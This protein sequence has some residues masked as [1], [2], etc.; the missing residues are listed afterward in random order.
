MLSPQVA[1]EGRLSAG[2]S[3]KLQ[4]LL[5]PRPR[6]D[7]VTS[8]VHSYWSKLV[9]SPARWKGREVEPTSGREN[10]VLPLGP[11]RACVRPPPQT[12]SRKASRS[13]TGTFAQS[14]CEGSLPFLIS[15]GSASAVLLENALLCL[16]SF[17]ICVQPGSSQRAAPV[18]ASI[19]RAKPSGVKTGDTSSSFKW[20]RQ[21]ERVWSAV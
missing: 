13:I 4:G 2:H 3:Q 5:R 6:I 11:A 21:R 18:G 19:W 10:S 14:S 1:I 16:L 7:C 12:A 9:P 20:T 8:P 17:A 15:H